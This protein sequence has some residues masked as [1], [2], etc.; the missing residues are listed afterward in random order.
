LVLLHSSLVPFL[1]VTCRNIVVTPGRAFGIGGLISQA[2]LR[3]RLRIIEPGVGEPVRQ[4]VFVFLH[5][6]DEA[7]EASA[8]LHMSARTQRVPKSSGFM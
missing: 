8:G 6:V 4:M 2:L 7:A 3:P 5:V 1:A